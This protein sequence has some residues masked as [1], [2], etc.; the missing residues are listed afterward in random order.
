[1]DSTPYL[2]SLLRTGGNGKSLRSKILQAALGA[3]NVKFA[4][5]YLLTRD[6]EFQ[7]S[8]KRI[9]GAM[10]VIFQEMK[11]GGYIEEVI[12]KNLFARAELLVRENHGKSD[13]ER[14]YA[15][16][17][18]DF[19]IE[20]NNA[21]SISPGDEAMEA[22]RR[23]LMLIAFEGDFTHD[24]NAVSVDNHVFLADPSLEDWVSSGV[25]GYIH[26]TRGIVPMV[27]KYTDAQS[28]KMLDN[29]SAR[30]E[31]VNEEFLQQM[32]MA[33]GGA[34]RVDEQPRDASTDPHELAALALIG[35][36]LDEDCELSDSKASVQKVSTLF[37]GS[38]D[39]KKGAWAAMRERGLWKPAQH[40]H[41]RKVTYYYPSMTSP[42][43]T[44]KLFPDRDHLAVPLTNSFP[45]RFI[46]HGLE[47]YVAS[48]LR[49]HN[50][51]A[52]QSHLQA[53][54]DAHTAARSRGR[55]SDEKVAMIKR[56]AKHASKL[57]WGE[58]AAL[59]L[60]DKLATTD[61]TLQAKYRFATIGDVCV[62]SRRHV[63]GLG[64][65]GTSRQLQ[66]VTQPGVVKLDFRACYLS[67]AIACLYTFLL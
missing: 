31:I 15:W 55:D 59:R 51:G 13:D 57:Q 2:N 54:Q 47:Q 4:S 28:Y 42:A 12:A 62:R 27:E 22:W 38:R 49:K 16:T 56:W 36:V 66:T 21:F 6:R 9:I 44:Q 33:G 52:I 41:G 25:A 53:I 18:T 58:D 10:V 24:T 19:V 5:A 48:P 35:V 20:L 60:R 14:S 65:Q 67:L 29:P 40:R 23:R 8:A 37:R 50:L 46:M 7:V 11:S 61:G 26:L 32:S 1:M 39:A 43:D 45:E 30:R 3:A 17:S 34:S 63:D 64:T